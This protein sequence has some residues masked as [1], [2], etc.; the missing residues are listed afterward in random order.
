[1]QAWVIDIWRKQRCFLQIIVHLIDETTNL[2]VILTFYLL[3]KVDVN[4]KINCHDDVLSLFVASIVSFL[5]YRVASAVVIYIRIK[6]KCRTLLQILDFELYDALI[7][8]YEQS[9]RGLNYVQRWI[10]FFRAVFEVCLVKLFYPLKVLLQL[11][12]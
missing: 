7:V 8:S 12:K 2:G 9:H 10:R 3:Y 1:M 6:N 4:G 11:Q 5:F